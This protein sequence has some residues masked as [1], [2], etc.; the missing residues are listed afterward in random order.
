MTKKENV[1]FI[2]NDHVDLA[3]IVEADGVHLGQE[4]LP[5]K[6]VRNILG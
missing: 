6:E 3:L 2:I 4:D 5:V 1:T